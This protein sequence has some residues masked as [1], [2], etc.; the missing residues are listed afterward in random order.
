[1]KASV[2]LGAAAAAVVLAVVALPAAAQSLPVD[3]SGRTV[4]ADRA[5][6]FVT[7][8]GTLQSFANGGGGGSVDNITTGDTYDA[9]LLGQSTAGAAHVTNAGRITSFT[10][11]LLPTTAGT[12][13][14]SNAP[15]IFSESESVTGANTRRV[16]VDV[17]TGDSS[18]LWISGLTIGGAPMDQGRLDV[19]GGAFTNG[20][21]WDNIPGPI[22][23]LTITN[24]L[25]IDGAAVA[26]SSPLTNL[27]T[28]PQ[29]GTAVV[30][31]GVV[32]SGVDESQMVF[33]IT[34]AAARCRLGV[35]Q[36]RLAGA[37]RSSPPADPR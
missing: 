26:T 22:T 6:G 34:F 25:F 19:G 3:A 2:L 10:Y 29:M 14:V 20:L 33:D 7:H 31:N 30:W 24:V 35:G 32:G 4:N 9:A 27:R 21:L 12:L 16:I 18:D 1:M 11:D 28:L 13:A 23:S 17:R 37:S 5:D 15:V 36:R 8:L